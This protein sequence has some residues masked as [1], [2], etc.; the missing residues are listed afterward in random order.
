MECFLLIKAS[1]KNDPWMKDLNNWIETNDREK[2]MSN[3]K[4]IHYDSPFADRD[5][6]E[7]MK[8]RIVVEKI[9]L[10]LMKFIT[11]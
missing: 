7:V 1:L 4:F 11:L 9:Y 2:R 8:K 6:L 3:I 10:F 5:F